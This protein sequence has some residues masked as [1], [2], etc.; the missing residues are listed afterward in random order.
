M[1]SLNTTDVTAILA[2][3]SDAA[4][5][6]QVSSEHLDTFVTFGKGARL[7][8]AQIADLILTRGV[9]GSDGKT[10]DSLRAYGD[11]IGIS[12]STLSTWTTAIRNVRTSGAVL[13]DATHD[14]ALTTYHA[15]GSKAAKELAET[16]GKRKG[17]DAKAKAWTAT[18]TKA[19]AAKAKAKTTDTSDTR[20]AQ[21]PDGT[22]VKA[23]TADVVAALVDLAGKF[24]D[25]DTSHVVLDED[26][27]AVVLAALAQIHAAIGV[28][29][30]V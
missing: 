15:A 1:T 6:V 8:I 20:A 28:T 23:T 18:A 21:T 29:V 11:R 2:L 3:Y 30:A 4:D 24:G 19:K 10:S 17:E 27:H 22:D 26:Q 9:V 16:I 7:V 13:T 5:D 25:A 12:G 14:A